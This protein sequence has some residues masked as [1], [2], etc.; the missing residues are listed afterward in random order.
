MTSWWWWW[1]C[2]YSVNFTTCWNC[3][4]G[5]CFPIFFP[6]LRAPL[7]LGSQKSS[8]TDFLAEFVLSLLMTPWLDLVCWSFTATGIPVN[9]FGPSSNWKAL[10]KALSTN[11][12]FMI[13][14]I[15]QFWLFRIY[16]SK[17]HHSFKC[18]KIPFLSYHLNMKYETLWKKLI[19]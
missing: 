9:D 2:N 11:V 16:L 6:L 18:Q 1:W 8:M 19:D 13:L 12:N 10:L 5:D 17:K 14:L 4:P 7:T 3:P 15:K